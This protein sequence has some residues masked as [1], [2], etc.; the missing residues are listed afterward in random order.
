MSAS[1]SERISSS[2]KPSVRDTEC[3]VLLYHRLFQHQAGAGDVEKGQLV[4]RFSFPL[5]SQSS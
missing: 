5:A 1:N 3:R 4:H 2:L